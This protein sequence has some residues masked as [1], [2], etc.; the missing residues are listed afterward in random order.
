MDQDIRWKQ[1][2]ANFQRAIQLL[3][4]VPELELDQ[5]SL[6]EKEGIIQRFEF[7]LELAWKTLKDKMEYDGLMLDRI[8]PK[9]VVKEAYKSKYIDDIETWL[10]MIDDRTSLSHANDHKVFEKVIPDIQQKYTPLLSELYTSLIEA[11]D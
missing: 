5:L 8:S 4:E 3:Q 9:M 1:R 2:F 6:L 7:T 10:K 11:Y